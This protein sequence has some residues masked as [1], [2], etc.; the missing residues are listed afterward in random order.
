MTRAA[1]EARR[2][3][4]LIPS[5]DSMH[6]L[7][8]VLRGHSQ[9]GAASWLP[10][11]PPQYTVL[12]PRQDKSDYKILGALALVLTEWAVVEEESG[13]PNVIGRLKGQDVIATQGHEMICQVE[14]RLEQSWNW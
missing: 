10:C 12:H 2:D 6:L 11:A 3:L 1:H 4:T 14:T 8:L 13:A 5:M 9:L 7:F